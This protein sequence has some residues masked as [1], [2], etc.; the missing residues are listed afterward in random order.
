M[1]KKILT[2]LL[3]LFATGILLTGCGEKETAEQKEELIQEE[4][5]VEQKKEL[6]QEEET[7]KKEE[8]DVEGNEEADKT[9]IM[10]LPDGF[11]QATKEELESVPDKEGL[12]NVAAEALSSIGV[13]EIE[14]AV[15][16]NYSI[17]ESDTLTTVNINSYSITEAKK[18]LISFMYIDTGNSPAS[19]VNWSVISVKDA[20]TGNIYYVPEDLKSTVDLYDY[21]TGEK[22]SEKTETYEDIQEKVEQEVKEA[23]QELEEN[24]DD[25]KEKNGY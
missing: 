11:V 10:D 15:Y 18:L 5:T 16:G 22:I 17:N 20:E 19:A 21:K 3:S 8:T 14:T 25:L 4:E 13:V 12:I 6:I 9:E 24:L 23:E 2:I 1:K 7:E